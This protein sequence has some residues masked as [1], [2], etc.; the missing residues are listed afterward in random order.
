[1]YTRKKII[2]VDIFNFLQV[3]GALD[4]VY[5]ESVVCNRG[6][7]VAEVKRTIGMAKS[8]V[9]KMHKIWNDR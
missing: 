9:G 4:T 7:S 2:V 1:M 8:A 3:T 5:L 6:S